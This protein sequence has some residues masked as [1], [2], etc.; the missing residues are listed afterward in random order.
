VRLAERARDAEVDV[1]LDITAGVPHVFQAFTDAI[2]EAGQALDRVGLRVGR[3]IGVK[4][5]AVVREATA[6][7]H[8]QQGPG[9]RADFVNFGSAWVSKS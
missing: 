9:E 6:P 4:W 1:I 8:G 2:D 7:L 5:R 3:L